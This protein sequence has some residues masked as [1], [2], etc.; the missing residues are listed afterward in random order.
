MDT[1][2]P[3]LTRSDL[4][5][6]Q[7]LFGDASM[8]R[9]QA[10][11]SLGSG[12]SGTDTP[13]ID[14][15]ETRQRSNKNGPA[16]SSCLEASN[17]TVETLSALNNPQHKDFEP[18]IFVGWDFKDIKLPHLINEYILR[19]YVNVGRRI[20]RV[21][22][23]VVMLTH[24][25]LYFATSVPSA[26]FLFYHFNWAHGVFH[27][28]MQS[29]Y[30]GTYT[31]MMHQHI[32]MGGILARK[33]SWLDTLFPYITNPLMGH[34]W[35][36]YYYHH[37]KHHHVE[38]NGPS[39]LSSTIRYQRDDLGDFLCYVGRFMFFIWLELPLYFLRTSKTRLAIKATFWEIS[40]YL[41]IFLLFKVN[42]KATLF[43]F[44]LPLLQLR[45]G[46]MVGNWGQHAFVDEMDP[47]S[48]FRSSI[49]LIDV[50]SNR[51]CFN[52]GYHTSHHLN[53]LRHWREHP[54][55]FLKQKKRYSEEFALVFHNID[56][57]ML[58][59][60]LMQKD[61][62]HLAKCLVPIGDQVHMTMDE[63]ATMLRTKTRRFTE[64]DIK[65]KFK[66][67]K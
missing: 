42:W 5:V 3:N 13:G 10:V 44:A 41:A 14:E 12:P 27:W 8:L 45:V 28:I 57:I 40:N 56:Y 49:T 67:N 1:I 2:D 33:Y 39:D 61:Y 46:L 25:L 65:K 30:V 20:V 37:V 11:A 54:V 58:T 66:V 52:D 34:T 38:G 18:T 17:T 32:H 64:E 26:I 35:N 21:E 43:V 31:L 9:S 62:V 24:L 60:K 63:I 47:D 15:C 29:Y 59:V 23:D 51:F 6:L 22:T 7:E 55:A 19:P 16:E 53:P 48:D 50:A 4:I 36:S